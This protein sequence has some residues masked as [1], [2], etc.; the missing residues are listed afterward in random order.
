[1]TN[2]NGK[3]RDDLT[4]ISILRAAEN[5]SRDLK[6]GQAQALRILAEKIRQSLRCFRVLLRRYSGNIDALDPQLKNNKELL[7]VVEVYEDSWALGKDQ[8][9]NP[10]YRSQ[11]T[12]TCLS[13]EE[14][15]RTNDKFKEHVSSFEADIF[16][17]IPSLVVFWG[18]D[19]RQE[20]SIFR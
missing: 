18:V 9:L 19:E 8:L 6:K 7:E 20:S 12:T 13:I 4:D 2:V 10:E 17:S 1:V 5:L 3:G 11:L 14:L 16:L 15:C